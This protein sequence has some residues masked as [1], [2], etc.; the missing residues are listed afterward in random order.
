M[1]E[2]EAYVALNMTGHIGPVGVRNLI[3][4]LGSAEAVFSAD[5][6]TLAQ[7]RGIGRE[8]A[9]AF[10]DSRARTEWTREMERAEREGVRLTTPADAEYPRTLL[11]IHDPP[12][13]LYVRGALRGNDRHA[14]AIVGTRR[15]TI[16]GR[17]CA[18]R[19]AYRLAQV[20][21][22]IV[23][24]LALGVDACA[25]EGAL[26]A[27]GRT[28]AVV[29]SALDCLYPP[30]NRELAERIARNG[31]VISEFP[32]G[33]KPDRTTFPMR[34][35]IVSGL[36]QGVLV[37]EAGFRSGALITARQALDQGRSVMAVPGR[38]DSPVSRGSHA[39]LKQGARL[40]E[41]IDDVLAEFEFLFPAAAM[42]APPDRDLQPD[43][44]A[45]ERAA[46]KAVED[47]AGTVDSLIRETGMAVG[48]ISS[49]LISLEMKKMLRMLPGRRLEMVR[50]RSMAGEKDG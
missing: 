18:E 40:V 30:A 25:H 37:V 19:F 43:L 14:L 39:L 12:L 26:K 23:S 35:R 32:F 42:A 46:V 17:E 48:E 5:A 9:R 44:T 3:D 1:T 13:A 16:Y 27:R 15:P 29:G 24:G 50:S 8:T 38:I 34:N 36:T 31:A 49:L 4:L 47:G 28:W 33:R 45:A 20:G 22:T 10:V 2:R 21:Y 11:E 7:G 6:A 41:N